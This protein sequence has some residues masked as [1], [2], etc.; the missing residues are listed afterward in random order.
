MRNYESSYGFSDTPQTIIV[1]KDDDTYEVRPCYRYAINSGNEGRDDMTNVARIWLADAGVVERCLASTPRDEAIQNIIAF[2]EELP[3]IDTAA[4]IEGRLTERHILGQTF[5]AAYKSKDEQTVY[6]ETLEGLVIRFEHERV[7]CEPNVYVRNVDGFTADAEGQT[8][9]A[10]E[11]RKT[12][13]GYWYVVKTQSMD[14][15]FDFENSTV[16]D[17]MYSTAVDVY[18]GDKIPSDAIR[19]VD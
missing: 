18:R 15:E 6:V 13:N 12:D 3:I 14:L 1:L 8:I 4:W 7:C 10:V 19:I 16:N 5:V 2:A 17:T 11:C 9:L